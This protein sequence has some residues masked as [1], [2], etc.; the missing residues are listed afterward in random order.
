MSTAP[1]HGRL[2]VALVCHDLGDGGAA[3]ATV[4]IARALQAHKDDRIRVRMFSANPV[5]VPG[6][7]VEGPPG[8]FTRIRR[9]ISR[10]RSRLADRLPWAT[11]NEAMHSRADVRTGMHR[12][13]APWSPDLVHLHWLGR[14]TMSVEEVGALP[15]PTV[16]TLHDM[17]VLLG[18][19]H[20][21]YDD[22]HLAG[23]ARA[24][25][26]E[27]ERG[28]DWNRRTWARKRAH[29]NRAMHLVTPSA[30]LTDTARNSVMAQGWQVST[31][32]NP[33]DTHFWRRL[34]RIHAREAL[35][36]PRDRRLL[37]A[38]TPEGM[39]QVKG[40]DLLREALALLMNDARLRA[41]P[42]ELI[43]IGS[44][45]SRTTG[46]EGTSMR[47][48][49]L[50]KVR[51]DLLLRL[52]YSA[53]DVT[54]VPSRVESFGQVAAESLACGTPVVAFGVGGLLDVVRDFSTGRLVR[55]GD[56]AALASA[57]AEMLL[58]DA[59]VRREMGAAGARDVAERFSPSLVADRYEQVY[60]ESLR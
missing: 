19:E 49:D 31:V 24:T 21:A 42:P 55:P 40:V 4:R 16:W 9:G 10:E 45:R 7:D 15:Y 39:S 18:A 34:D 26:P 44:D 2:K 12:S 30:W 57:T 14:G 25:R 50:G 51:Q 56:A 22:R 52:V 60:R 17:W 36:L 23:Y 33:V 6:L 29:W 28:V 1:E 11:P 47:I 37:L 58:L 38:S 5:E 35:G 48:H 43:V 27:G 41:D 54:L 59:D 32:P 8:G 3:R 20:V 53:A 46:F 13:L